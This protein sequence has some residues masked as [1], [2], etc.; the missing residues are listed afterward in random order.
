MVDPTGWTFEQRY[1]YLK[2]CTP[3][4]WESICKQCGICCLHKYANILGKTR[5][6]SISCEHF[7]I[8]TK[9]CSCYNVR[10]NEDDCVKVDLDLV[11]ARKLIPASC[12]YVEFLYGPA[13]YPAQFDFKTAKPEF[14]CGNTD[15]LT[16]KR[17]LIPESVNWNRRKKR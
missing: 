16:L 7:D 2:N 14:L 5:Y 8:E 10:L 4:E 1:N 11:K 15:Y 17:N 6:T 12:G 9:K 3:K 13:P